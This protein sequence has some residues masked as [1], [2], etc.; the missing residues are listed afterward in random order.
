[1]TTEQ[2]N[3]ALAAIMVEYEDY[4]QT[5]VEK[6]LGINRVKNIPLNV[7]DNTILFPFP[8]EAGVDY[9]I[10]KAKAINSEGYDIAFTI[11][12]DDSPTG[13]TVT[14]EE[15]CTFQ[16]VAMSYEEWISD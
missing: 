2:L 13:F 16:Y 3:E 15:S 4:V 6:M 8:Y 12:N 11:S 10:V 7:G 5:I 14:V 9:T 1:M